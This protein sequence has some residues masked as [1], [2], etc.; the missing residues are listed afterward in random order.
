M[1][2]KLDKMKSKNTT[3]RDKYSTIGGIEETLS[4]TWPL[5]ELLFIFVL[6]RGE[7]S[8]EDS[9]YLKEKT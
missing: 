8:Y 6:K 5:R 7:G 9:S 3:R 4:H 1:G 2:G